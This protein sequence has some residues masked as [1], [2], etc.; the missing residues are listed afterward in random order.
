[1]PTAEKEKT[2]GPAT[3]DLQTALS[4][5]ERLEAEAAKVAADAERA[6]RAAQSAAERAKAQQE[7]AHRAWARQVV[8]AWPERG[9]VLRQ[10]VAAARANFTAAV[11][12]AP[13]AVLPRYCAY[14]E[15]L[16]EDFAGQT[17]YAQAQNTLGNTAVH[18]PSPPGTNFSN[19]LNMALGHHGMVLIDEA[20]Q[21]MRDRRAAILTGKAKS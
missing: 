3:P 5:A 13:E 19:D 6:R 18:E 20:T 10:A 15:A 4:E 17:E 1:M 8:K 2:I 16:A 14:L 11:F 7:E 9:P 12:D 21:R